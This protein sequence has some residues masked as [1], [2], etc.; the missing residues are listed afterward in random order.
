MSSDESLMAGIH[1]AAEAAYNEAAYLA[2]GSQPGLAGTVFDPQF[3]VQRTV[4]E[5]PPVTQET[6]AEA[7]AQFGVGVT[8]ADGLPVD[9]MLIDGRALEP[10]SKV[11]LFSTEDLPTRPGTPTDML[12]GVPAVVDFEGV[13]HRVESSSLVPAGQVY[14][15]DEGA[16]QDASDRSLRE[17]RAA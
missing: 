16:M 5:D 2:D 17:W 3:V 15:I 7:F 12:M 9:S 11:L 13:P 10:P 8:V 4:P 1:R 6:L 14:V